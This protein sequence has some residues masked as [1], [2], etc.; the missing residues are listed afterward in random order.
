MVKRDYYDTLGVTR[1]ATKA[2][3]RSAYRKLARKYHP[4]VNKSPDAADKF[5]EATEAYEVL[6]DPKKRKMYNQFGH[7]GVDANAAGPGRRRQW[8]GAGPEGVSFNVEDLFGRGVAG[9]GG[10]MRM[11]L[12]EIM[13]ALGGRGRPRRSRGAS[14]AETRSGDLEQKISLD[15]MQAIYGTTV[16]LRVPVDAANGRTLTQTINVKIPPGV[17]DGAK[18]RV[19]GKGAETP[20]G[21]GN[22]YI[23]THV[24]EHPY[25]RRKDDDIYLEFP[26]S[27][28]E[29]T[30]GAKVDVPTVQGMTTV[31]IPPGTGSSKRLRLR[32][33]GVRSANGK[34]SGDQYVLVEIV[35][36]GKIS[37]EGAKLLRE[38]ESRENIDPRNN[39][40]WK[41]NT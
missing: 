38:F 7:A 15:F 37:T 6:S 33:K 35:A 17:R 10:F 30:L 8:S 23:I 40:P 36:P 25:F 19:R 2:Q 39:M 13:A 27:I 18:I 9:G 14:A 16:S 34:T 29:A 3:I 24:R 20:S 31:K 4:D 11:S 26:I 12:E 32:G 22:L 1:D 41:K 28:T 5:K 21:R